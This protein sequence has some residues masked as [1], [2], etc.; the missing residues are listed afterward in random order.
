MLCLALLR[1]FSHVVARWTSV[2]S[3]PVPKMG[4]M[5]RGS[6]ALSHRRLLAPNF[7]LSLVALLVI[8]C[9]VP[10]LQ[11]TPAPPTP[12]PSTPVPPTP[13]PATPLA[14]PTVASTPTLPVTTTVRVLF[15]GNSFTFFNNL[16]EM[17]AELARSGGHRVEVDMS[18]Q[19]GWTCADHATS[20]VT[21]DKIEQQEWDFVVLQEQSRIPVTAEERDEQMYPAVR[22]LD[23]RIRESGTS[24]VLF[25]TWAPRN[26]LAGVAYAAAQ[27]Q[28]Q[29]GYME[30]ANELD[31][32]V[33]PVGIAWQA[34]ITQDPQLGLWNT[35]GLH[36]AREGTYLSACVFYAVIFRQ[37]PERVT[38]TAGLSGE[39]A[40]FLQATAAEAVLE[41]RGSWNIR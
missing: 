32:M 28:L 4:L 27:A 37:S 26:G 20:A 1:G 35:D 8:A 29:A 7:G 40:R 11:F 6:D 19:G 31:A 14:V 33:A 39:M 36:P 9:G 10:Q 24:T 41:D 3:K 22:L 23:R 34:G 13:V 17:F 15:T 16:H 2:E 21:L 5:R 12:V 18:A 38:Y 30:I 25:M